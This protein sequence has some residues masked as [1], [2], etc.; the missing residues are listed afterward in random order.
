MPK[1]LY[2]A[3]EAR[4]LLLSG[5]NKLADTVKITLGPKGRSVLLGR[6][7]GSPVITKDGVSVAKDINLKNETENMG[8]NIIK[9]A[10]MKSNDMAGDGTTTATILAQAIINEGLSLVA[11]G[12]SPLE[13]KD[14]I[15]KRTAEIVSKLK[16][17]SVEIKTEEELS[18]VASISSN[19]KEIGEIIG[20]VMHRIGKEGIVTVE[21]GQTMGVESSTVEGMQFNRGYISPYMATNQTTMKAEIDK[22]YILL[23]DQRISLTKDL[24]PILTK[25]TDENIT[26]LVIIADDVDGDAMSN[27]LLHK[28]RGTLK[29]ICIKAPGFGD[30]KKQLLEDIAIVTGGKIVSADTGI[31][32]NSVSLEDLG[33]AGKVVSTKDNTTIIDGGGSKEAIDER[34]SFLKNEISIT[35][36][37]FEKNKIK[38]RLAKLTGGVAVLKVGA[39]TEVEMKEKKDR[40][41]DAINAT[42]AAQEEG[43]VPG[44]GLALL[45]AGG[46]INE[47][48]TESTSHGQSIVDR[49]ILSPLKQIATNA[50]KDGSLILFNVIDKNKGQD[51]KSIGY[52]ASSDTYVDMFLS[53][54]IDPTKVVRSSLE[55]AASAA[56]MFLTIDAVVVDSEDTKDNNQII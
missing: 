52:D 41:E 29:I 17:I 34:I 21:E 9:E 18:H 14:G 56:M 4:Q 3:N 30:H 48:K 25:L 27:I 42:K 2:F 37:S 43:V 8:A 46:I 33:R 7:Y 28:M 45:I 32:F 16:E 54:I 12:I 39:L 50:G 31:N 10:S 15:E 22:A 47:I 11:S 49:A 35:T 20:K 44:G 40:I 51:K 23:T 26:E 19:S 1:E 55:N 6:K 53:G 36:D 24:I 13:I 5:A 38:E